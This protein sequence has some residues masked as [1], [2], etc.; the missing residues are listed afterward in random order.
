LNDDHPNAPEPEVAL[1][2][3][4]ELLARFSRGREPRL[5]EELVVRFGPLAESLARRYSDRGERLEDLEQVAQLGLL[6]AI[7]GFDERRGT[8]FRAYAEPT[9]L[10]EIRRHFRDKRWA[11]RVPRDL[12]EALP[13]IRSAID[14]LST[15]LG[16]EPVT[17]EVAEAANMDEQEVLEALEAAETSRP[18]SLD[19]PIVAGEEGAT[20]M[21]EQ[22]GVVDENLEQAE[23]GVMLSDRLDQLDPRQ[24]EVLHL[25]FVED[26]TQREIG[27]RIGVSQMQVSRI[28]RDTLGRLRERG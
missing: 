17:E 23:W 3:D 16:R 13:R 2:S 12:K 18:T 21:G 24:R 27:E 22:V 14:Q 8:S 19:A 11:M 20:P 6:K 1:E 7:D 26:L 28:I 15:E 9:I 10:G 5:R 4:E 25:R